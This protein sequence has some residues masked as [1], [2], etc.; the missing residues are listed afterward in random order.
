MKRIWNFYFCDSYNAVIG[1]FLT[2]GAIVCI[3]NAVLGITGN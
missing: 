2:A 3:M 1:L